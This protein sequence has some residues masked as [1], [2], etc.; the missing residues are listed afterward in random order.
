MKFVAYGAAGTVTGSMHVLQVNGKR[1]LFDCGLF[2]GKRQESFDR[3]RNLPFNA[4]DIDAVVLS[5]AHLDHVGVIPV[6]INGGYRGPIYCTQATADVARAILLDSAKIQESDTAYVNRRRATE[7][8]PLVEPLYSIN[9]AMRSLRHFVGVGYDYTFDIASGVALTLRDAGHILGSAICDI[10]AREA[11]RETRFV[12]SGDL[13]RPVSRIL[14]PPERL[15]SADVLVMESTYGGRE[16]GPIELTDDEL[17]QVVQRT[18][19]RGGKLIIPAFAVGRTQE[20]VY[21][22]NRLHTSGCIPPLPI[23]V[24]SPLAINVTEAF[25]THADCFNDELLGFMRHDAD[26]NAFTFDQLIYTRNVDDSKA[27]NAMAGPLIIIA[28]SGMAEAGR[29]QHH[30][31]HT[32]GDPRNTVLVVG[33]MAE[34][35]LGR[36]IMDKQPVVRIFGEEFNLRA[37]V[38]TLTGFSAHADHSE[39]MD[40]ASAMNL[41]KVRDLFLVHG[42]PEAQKALAAALTAAGAP[43]VRLA[44]QGEFVDLPAA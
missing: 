11:G 44:R 27:L 34:N 3:N 18:A 24:D 20:L 31:A 7:G 22:L 16:H 29:V 1:I 17:C 36:R 6:L 4:R 28:A 12:F 25:R 10:R 43:R 26:H 38:V 13:G 32:I 2:Q 23:Y 9:E 39:L 40:W 42:E 30:L 5:H 37:E 33:Y 41:P 14:R 19:G 15:D 21:A 8:Q 35:T